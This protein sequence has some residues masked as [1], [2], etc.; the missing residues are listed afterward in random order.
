M[1]EGS[2]KTADQV[3][4]VSNAKTQLPKLIMEA[5]KLLI[6]V[7]LFGQQRLTVEA[8]LTSTLRGF[9]ASQVPSNGGCLT[10]PLVG[11]L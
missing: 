7:T 1:I 4:I 2:L 9:T 5:N 6:E 10:I 8:E 3:V 11:L